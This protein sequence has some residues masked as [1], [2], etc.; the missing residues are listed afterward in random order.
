MPP[1]HSAI[2]NRTPD[3]I[4]AEA[5]KIGMATSAY[6]ERLLTSRDHIEQGVR[7]CLGILRLAAKYPA[8]RLE[9]ACQCALSAG[10][11]SSGYVEQLLKQPRA[12]PDPA[13][14]TGT[15]THANV[16]GAGYYQH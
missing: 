8:A 14:D 2:A 12:I 7:S 6:V 9:S 16:R 5:A 1:A 4:R 10:V 11:R 13:A 15:A 3:W